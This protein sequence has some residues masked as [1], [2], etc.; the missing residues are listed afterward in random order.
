[1]NV[2]CYKEFDAISCEVAVLILLALKVYNCI[3]Q[4][5]GGLLIFFLNTAVFRIQ[6]ILKSHSKFAPLQYKGY[7]CVSE[8]GP[9]IFK[10]KNW[11]KNDYPEFI[12]N[13]L[14]YF[15]S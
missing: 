9:Q 12:K 13:H 8:S 14:Y 1:M 5:K 11:V 3:L 15:S 2:A 10:T 6:N 4:Y 7:V